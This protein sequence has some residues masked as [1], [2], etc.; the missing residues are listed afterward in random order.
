MVNKSRDEIAYNIIDIEGDF[1]AV[2]SRKL[3]RLRA[4][5]MFAFSD[6]ASLN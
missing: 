4:W 6:T 1:D 2:C 3:L 5:F